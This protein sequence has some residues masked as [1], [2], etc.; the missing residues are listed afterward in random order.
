MT[1]ITCQC[2]KNIV[3]LSFAFCRSVRHAEGAGR[4]HQLH[5]HVVLRHKLRRLRALLVRRLRR[6][7]KQIRN[8]RRVRATVQVAAW[9]RFVTTYFQVVETEF[10]WI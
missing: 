9:N 10:N 5:C 8:A 1:S 4:V 6:K 3:T 2:K 7:R